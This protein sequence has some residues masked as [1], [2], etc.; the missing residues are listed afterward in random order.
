MITVESAGDVAFAATKDL[1]ESGA[2]LVRHNDFSSL[3]G[4]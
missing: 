1:P 3:T 2:H 4:I